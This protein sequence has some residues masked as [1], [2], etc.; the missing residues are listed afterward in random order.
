MPYSSKYRDVVV[1]HTEEEG[2]YCCNVPTCPQY[3]QAVSHTAAY[4]HAGEEHQQQHRQ[5]QQEQQQQAQ[6]H[7]QEQQPEA[8]ASDLARE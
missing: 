3:G 2:R 4:R 7:E 5:Q 6:E 1:R 8:H